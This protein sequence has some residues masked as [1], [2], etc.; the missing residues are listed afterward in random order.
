MDA[1][2]LSPCAFQRAATSVWWKTPKKLALCLGGPTLSE[3]LQKEKEEE[4]DKEEG[5]G[6]ESRA[7]VRAGLGH[8]PVSNPTS[9]TVRASSRS[10]RRGLKAPLV[11]P[12]SE[13]TLG[14]SEEAASG[15]RRGP[16]QHSSQTAPSAS[17]GP[18]K[19]S[20]LPPVTCLEL[21][22][23]FQRGGRRA[24]GLTISMQLIIKGCQ[25]S[26]RDLAASRPDAH[27]M[28]HSRCARHPHH[29]SALKP[30]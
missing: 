4:S 24:R 20:A 16:S 6:G 13:R 28:S 12:S 9:P 21:N 29:P 19:P 10:L 11:F 23:Q 14:P 5:A 1:S 30:H 7:C 17:A 25:M 22:G 26:E 15:G 3:T 2:G 8:G 27:H 18:P